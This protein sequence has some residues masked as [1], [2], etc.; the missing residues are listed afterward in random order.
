VPPARARGR[1]AR[2][3]VLRSLQPRGQ[4]AAAELRESDTFVGDEPLVVTV[5]WDSGERY[6]TAGTFDE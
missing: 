1:T 3:P 6:L 5:F 2:R 4:N